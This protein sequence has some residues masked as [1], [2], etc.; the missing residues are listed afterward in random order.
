MDL[1]GYVI[2]QELFMLYC[3]GFCAVGFI[4]AFIALVVALRVHRRS[5]KIL[6]DGAGRDITEAII[7]YYKK[8][9][10][11]M[12]DYKRAEERL[13]KLERDSRACAKK[14]GAIRYNAFGG[15]NS[16]LSYAVAV[17]DEQNTGFVLNG[18][19]ARQ[20]TATYLKPIQNGQS[21]FELS[22]EEREAIRTAQLNYEHAI[23]AQNH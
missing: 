6:K 3:V 2:P 23:A 19:Y 18:V 8:C 12:D 1:F 22:D 10:D 11:I 13:E 14:V 15:N 21:L 16:N 9:T 5:K 17:L 7:N 20:Q 4:F